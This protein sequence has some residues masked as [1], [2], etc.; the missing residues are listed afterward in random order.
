LCEIDFRGVALGLEVFDSGVAV[1]VLIGEP[2]D[3][4]TVVEDEEGV[5]VGRMRIELGI[6]LVVD[7]V[8]VGVP[9]AVKIDAV[10]LELVSLLGVVGGAVVLAEEDVTKGSLVVEVLE[11]VAS[12]VLSELVSKLLAELSCVTISDVEGTAPL[13]VEDVNEGEIETLLKDTAATTCI[14]VFEALAATPGVIAWLI[15]AV[16]EDSKSNAVVVLE[17]GDAEDDLE[18]DKEDNVEI[19]KLVAL[20]PVDIKVDIV[21]G[22]EVMIVE[23]LIAEVAT[24]DR[25]K[26]DV[27]EK[28]VL[29]RL[30]VEVLMSLDADRDEPAGIVVYSTTVV[31]EIIVD[32]AS[33]VSLELGGIVWNVVEVDVI[34]VSVVVRFFVRDLG[35]RVTSLQAERAYKH[36]IT[37]FVQ[38]KPYRS[39]L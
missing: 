19:D 5:V 16:A 37:I 29:F 20:L 32:S 4:D 34:V 26:L 22:I 18:N 36:R 8:T 6:A 30:A 28:V 3:D 12:G 1:A 10:L 14:P 17:I 27:V 13:A 39:L 24:D 7:S 21:V 23:E 11:V 33:V 35:G 31:N 2:D 9:D 15:A 25:D 38:E